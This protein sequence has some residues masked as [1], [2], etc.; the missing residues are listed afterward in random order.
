MITKEIKDILKKE[1]EAEMEE[2]CLNWNT[3]RVSKKQHGFPV[4]WRNLHAICSKAKAKQIKVKQ[5]VICKLL[6]H[7]NYKYLITDIKVLGKK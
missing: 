2:K 6:D 1:I 4:G 3:V 7:F 5:F